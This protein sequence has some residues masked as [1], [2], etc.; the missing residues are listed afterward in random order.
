VNERMVKRMQE[1]T[2]VPTEKKRIRLEKMSHKIE[3]NSS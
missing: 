3:E 2:A 1:T